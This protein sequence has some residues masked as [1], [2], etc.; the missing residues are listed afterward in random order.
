MNVRKGGSIR[1]KKIIKSVES[2]RKKK[3]IKSVR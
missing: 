3:I 1:D 2:I